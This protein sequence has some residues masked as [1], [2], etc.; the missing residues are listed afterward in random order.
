MNS[1][2]I[3]AGITILALAVSFSAD[4]KKTVAGIKKGLKMF[5]NLLPAVMTIIILVSFLLYF[6]PQETIV[7]V[8]GN[9][10]G[11]LAKVIAALIGSISLIPGFIAY[12]LC[13]MLVKSGV[14]YP[15]IAIFATT[16]MMVG[17]VTLPIEKKYFGMRAALV[18]N[19]LSF[20][21]A[22]IIGLFVGLVW[23]LV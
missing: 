14:S 23:G 13:G 18:R 5:I 20:A 8:L 17:I 6:I 19:A 1:A 21:G 15:V 11:S 4:R 3:A 22:L 12:P 7:K 2:V 9:S 10:A 16:L